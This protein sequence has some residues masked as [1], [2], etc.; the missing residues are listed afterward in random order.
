MTRALDDSLR[1]A[2]ELGNLDSVGAVGRSGTHLMKEHDLVL[3][4]LHVHRDIADIREA[5]GKCRQL[6]ARVA[7]VEEVLGGSGASAAPASASAVRRHRRRR[8]RVPG[9]GISEA[10]VKG[11]LGRGDTP[12]TP[13]DF[14]L[15]EIV[16]PNDPRGI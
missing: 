9:T 16:D 4:F 2:R 7:G 15:P 12:L 6:G 11:N 10:Q 8:P 13:A 1:E 5:S 3:P 14:G